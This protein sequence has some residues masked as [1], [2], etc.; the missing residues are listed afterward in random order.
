MWIGEFVIKGENNI[1]SPCRYIDI[2]EIKLKGMQKG[3]K[4][5]VPEKG[6]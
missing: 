2:G 3:V 4:E 6:R 1:V 5:D